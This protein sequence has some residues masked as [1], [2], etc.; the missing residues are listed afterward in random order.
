MA[1]TMPAP[2]EHY[3]VDDILIS[4]LSGEQ[5]HWLQQD[6]IGRVREITDKPVSHHEAG[7]PPEAVAAAVAEGEAISPEAEDSTAEK[8][9]A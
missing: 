7:R 2:I 3:R 6:L 9:E 4:T 1:E 8:S 5:S